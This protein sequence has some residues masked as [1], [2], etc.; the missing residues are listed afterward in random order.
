M[1]NQILSTASGMNI[2]LAAYCENYLTIL[3]WQY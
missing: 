1:Q 3:H 2:N